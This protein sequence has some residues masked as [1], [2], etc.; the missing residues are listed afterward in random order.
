MYMSMYKQGPTP[1]GI[2]S[3]FLVGYPQLRSMLKF[4][5]SHSFL[6]WFNVTS[7]NQLLSAARIVVSTSLIQIHLLEIFP[8]PK[9]HKSNYISI[10]SADLKTY[11][12][13]VSIWCARCENIF[14]NRFEKLIILPRCESFSHFFSQLKSVLIQ[15][16]LTLVAA[17]F[18]FEFSRKW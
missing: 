7:L 3:P 18:Q 10:S 16:C 1:T 12:R 11:R 8:P 9:P 5:Q 14:R 13:D 4:R 2:A 17:S 15:C 6:M